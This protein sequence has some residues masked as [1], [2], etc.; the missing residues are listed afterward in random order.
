[1]QQTLAQPARS[2]PISE[3]ED[4]QHFL[5]PDLV[6]RVDA[7]LCRVG[8]FG[9]VRLVVVKGRLRF[10]QVVHSESVDES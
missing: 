5:T 1:M 7:A 3:A 4:A 8:L 6:R 2:T 9:E 10:I